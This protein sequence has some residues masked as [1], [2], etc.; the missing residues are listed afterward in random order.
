MIRATVGVTILC[1]TG[2]S[3]TVPWPE[4][5]D[6][7][8]LDSGLCVEQRDAWDDYDVDLD[9]WL[10]GL[11]RGYGL[12]FHGVTLQLHRSQLAV[13]GKYMNAHPQAE[14]PPSSCIAGWFDDETST[15]VAIPGAVVH[16]MTHYS[17]ALRGDGLVMPQ[18]TDV[19]PYGDLKPFE[20]AHSPAMGWHPEDTRRESA[21]AVHWPSPVGAGDLGC[22]DDIDLKAPAAKG[23]AVGAGGVRW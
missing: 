12:D 2:C 17:L 22:D 1:I 19:G 9:D 5:A 6:G 18:N 10:L 4:C 7:T 8:L 3:L 21:I 16:E 23:V 14:F 15:L 11:S 13:H 20:L